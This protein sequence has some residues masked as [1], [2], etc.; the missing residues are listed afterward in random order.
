[1][2]DP[3]EWRKK[4]D[5]WKN[6][7]PTSELFNLPK[8]DEGTDDKTYLPEYEYEATVTP[9]GTSVEKHKRI[10]NEED[11]QKYW[12]DVGAGYVNKAQE[13][14]A[15]Y[16]LNGMSMLMGNPISAFAGIGGEIFGSELGAK[17]SPQASAIGGLVGGFAL[18]PANLLRVGQIGKN[19]ANRNLFAYKYIQPWGYDNPVKRGTNLVKHLLTDTH[20]PNP[21]LNPEYWTQ[22]EDLRAIQSFRDDAWRK[23]LGIPERFGIY[24]PNADGTFSYNLRKIKQIS[25]NYA[26]DSYA[27][28]VVPDGPEV[29]GDWVTGNG[30]NVSSKVIDFGYGVGSDSN[31]RFG[32]LHLSDLWDVQPFSRSLPSWTKALPKSVQK[33]IS[34]FEIGPLVKGRPFQLETDVPFTI[35]IN[36]DESGKL[37]REMAPEFINDNIMPERYFNYMTYGSP[38]PPNFNTTSNIRSDF[39]K[40]LATLS[41]KHDKGKSIHINPANRGKFTATK[42][43]TG[44][45]TEQLAHSKN[46]LTR[47]RA[48]FAL[49][50]RKFKH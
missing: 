8:Y 4:F 16:V 38:E 29:I 7:T 36:V 27:P 37:G 23:Y 50:S 43:R 6:G 17:I 47:K 13:E 18:D 20:V 24:T 11:W 2:K 15:P 28:M 32:M 19:I 44:K 40:S 41:K 12:G 45:T 49:N 48:I 42:K 26:I 22:H 34:N 1:M 39:S 35:S 25:P 30:G 33:K 46:P 21:E 10:T 14:A 5:A 31:K 3:T 9:Q